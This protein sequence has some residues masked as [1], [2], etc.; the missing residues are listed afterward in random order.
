MPRTVPEFKLPPVAAPS[1][2][3]GGGAPATWIRPTGRPLEFETFGQERNVTL[4]PFYRL[5]DER[6]AV[7]WEFRSA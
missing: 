5:F 1:F 2:A 7:Y 6:Y 3:V 4:V